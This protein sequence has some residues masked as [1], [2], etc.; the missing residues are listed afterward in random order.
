MDVVAAD[1][2]NRNDPAEPKGQ[3]F[4]TSGS[5]NPSWKKAAALK[6]QL[7]QKL[8]LGGVK[9]AEHLPPRVRQAINSARGIDTPA[10]VNRLSGDRVVVLSPHPDD[11][12]IGAGGAIGTHVAAG[13]TVLIVQMTSG[14]AT[15][16]LAHLPPDER[17]AKREGEARL[18]AE[19][20]GL[21]PSDVH[22]VG[23]GDGNVG[24]AQ[25]SNKNFDR[26][27]E[28]VA[29]YEPDLI[30]A[31]WP[32]DAHRDHV[33]TTQLLAQALRM[34]RLPT[35]AAVALYEVWTPLVPTHLVDIGRYLDNK[36]YALAA[37]QSALESVDYLHTARGMAAYRSAQ[38]LHG[39]GYAEAFCVL[40]P[41]ALLELLDTAL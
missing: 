37:Y 36:L 24:S 12:I 35:V 1:I 32:V 18:A 29:D 25:A 7:I 41:K 2:P 39:R 19:R 30:Y 5:N 10:L 22:F 13:A 28:V 9:A 40:S 33:A 31:P 8:R 34:G 27:V 21:L 17:A 14:E 11:E 3:V 38:G 4:T 6:N 16:G 20:L 26:F 23:Y 15:V